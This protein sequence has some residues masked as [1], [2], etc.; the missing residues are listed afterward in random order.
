MTPYEMIHSDNQ[1]HDFTAA[2]VAEVLIK[3]FAKQECATQFFNTFRRR[4][5]GT[6]AHRPGAALEELKPERLGEE[7]VKWLDKKQIFSRGGELDDALQQSEIF[8]RICSGRQLDLHEEIVAEAKRIVQVAGNT[9]LATLRK[10]AEHTPRKAEQLLDETCA[11]IASIEEPEVGSLPVVETYRL[12]TR[13]IREFAALADGTTKKVV[14]EISK[15]AAVKLDELRVPA[16]K[17]FGREITKKAALEDRTRLLAEIDIV[18]KQVSA[19]ESKMRA[20]SELLAARLATAKKLAKESEAG[21]QLVLPGLDV[22]AV[23]HQLSRHHGLASDKLLDKKIGDLLLEGLRRRLTTDHSYSPEV[24]ESLPHISVLTF[25]TEKEI[26]ETLLELVQDGVGETPVYS[27][28]SQ[29]KH[30]GIKGAAKRLWE[31]AMPTAGPNRLAVPQLGVRAVPINLVQLP[32]SDFH[33][34]TRE[35]LIRAFEEISESEGGCN[36]VPAPAGVKS[37]TVLRMIVGW[38]PVLESNNGALL[39]AYVMAAREGH[40][41]HLMGFMNTDDAS[42][43]SE[44][45]DLGKRLN[46][47]L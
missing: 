34:D 5:L 15:N 17:E 6:E 29:Y 37:V 42:A 3:S 39:S 25:V 9:L 35:A 40:D 47:H 38:P 43:R 12:L 13:R 10:S 19:F 28:L 4:G 23:R 41:P 45:I 46:P 8:E 16:L 20:V 27:F 36:C 26:V 31:A 7:F 2:G 14:A 21:Y 32:E 22:T 11:T 18:R 1:Y 44:I 30:G 33:A 24:V